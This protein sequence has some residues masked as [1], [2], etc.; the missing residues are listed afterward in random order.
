MFAA[1]IEGNYITFLVTAAS[2]CERP[3]RA[4]R[5]DAVPEILL[6]RAR[7]D[8]KQED[9]SHRALPIRARAIASR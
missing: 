9:D 6:G 4:I 5:D 3:F 8:Q 7:S 1:E 2:E